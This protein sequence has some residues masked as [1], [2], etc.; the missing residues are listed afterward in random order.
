M[1]RYTH[2]L[3]FLAILG[4]S[5]AHAA[6]NN[7]IDAMSFSYGEDLDDNDTTLYRFGLQNKWER[8][9]LN[10]GAW[11][12]G[13]YWDA[14]LAYM[15]SDHKNSENDELFDSRSDT[16]IQVATRR[17]SF[18]RRITLRGTRYRSAP[19][20]GN[21]PRQ[22]AVLD[23]LAVRLAWWALGWALATRGSTN[24]PTACS[25]SPMATSRH[26]TRA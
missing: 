25:T 11:Y 19:D 21:P 9:W 17:Q 16:G 5:G 18:Q 14:E 23:R 4:C 7:W 3:F 6:G 15:E 22:A 20:L 26:P 8:T 24:F 13:G 10:G 2:W 1:K 12:V